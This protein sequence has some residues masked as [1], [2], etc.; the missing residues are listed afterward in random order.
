VGRRSGR[1]DAGII[2]EMIQQLDRQQIRRQVIDVKRILYTSV[3]HCSVSEETTS[4][5]DEDIETVSVRADGRSQVF[6]RIHVRK[7]GLN[8]LG[9]DSHPGQPV[10]NGGP[11]RLVATVDNYIG[12]KSAKR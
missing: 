9:F 4:V 1:D 5:V 10:D 3:S 2:S 6:D 7:I 8:E 12:T 11:S